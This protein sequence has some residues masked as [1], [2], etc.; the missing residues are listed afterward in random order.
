[1][2]RLWFI[3]GNGH[4]PARRLVTEAPDYFSWGFVR[5]PYDRLVSV[6]HSVVKTVTEY[7]ETF[8]RFVLDLPRCPKNFVHVRKQVEFLC[9]PDGSVAVDF[10][11]RFES[12]EDDWQKVCGHIGV[13]G[14]LPKLNA[15][16]HGPWADEHTPATIKHTNELY[17]DDFSTFGY[18]QI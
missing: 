11:G 3:G 12:L 7:A 13:S 5:N 4:N 6:Y 14:P 8:E 2:E 17:A 1:M 16:N 9:W 18:E 15:T 10:V